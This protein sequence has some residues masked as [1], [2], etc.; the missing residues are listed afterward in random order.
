MTAVVNRQRYTEGT[1]KSKREAKQNAAKKALDGIK[2]TQNTESVSTNMLYRL[3]ILLCVCVYYFDATNSTVPY[4]HWYRYTFT[5]IYTCIHK[6]I[7]YIFLYIVSAPFKN[8]YLI[9][10]FMFNI[11]QNIISKYILY[12]HYIILRIII[13][14]IILF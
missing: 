3:G 12:I 10:N 4:F 11:I 14:I 9:L 2:S 1:G 6:Y 7:T 8:A 5:Y 13:I